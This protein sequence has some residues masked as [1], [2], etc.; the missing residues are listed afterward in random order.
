MWRGLVEQA[1]DVKVM[2]RAEVDAA[3][4]DGGYG[5]ADGV[6]GAVAGAVL[7]AVVE[8]VGD[9][10]CIVGMEDGVAVDLPLVPFFG[11]GYPENCVA[12]SVS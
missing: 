6:V 5:E 9:V 2:A 7:F 3:V 4:G 8:L 11:G 12:V 10:G 1:I